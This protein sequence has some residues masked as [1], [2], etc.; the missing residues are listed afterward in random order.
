M[1][2][3]RPGDFLWATGIEDTFVPQSRPGHRALDEYQ[4]MG[5]YD[6]WRGDLALLR[7]TGVRAVRW[8]V[9][10][11][12]VEPLAGEYDW[13]WT[14]A[15]LPYL[16]EELGITPIVD[17]MHYGCPFWLRREFASDEYP[18]AVAAY[19]GAFAER[20]RHL[21]HW[22]TPLNE[23]IV[24][25]LFCGKRGLWPPYL[26]SDAGYV[27][28][29][30]QATRGIL[31]TIAA[32]READA[33]AILVHVDASGLS[34]TAR[35][36]LA[37]LAQ[38]EQSRT[39]LPTDLVTGRVT[40]EHSLFAWLVRSGASPDELARIAAKPATIDYLGLN[41]YP[42]WSTTQ[43]YIDRRGRLAYR[44]VEQEGEGFS[45]LIEEYH[46]RFQLPIIVTET[47]ARGGEDVR[48]RWL[49]ASVSAIRELRAHG[50]PVLGYTW[51]PL[52]TMVDWRYRFGRGPIEEYYLE[53]GLYTLRRDGAGGNG[54]DVGGRWNATPLVEQYRSYTGDAES[55]IGPLLTDAGLH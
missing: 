53:L 10:W 55:A 42:Q 37:A 13:R 22:Y 23:P 26:R 9:P 35:T 2:G 8:G 48:A 11:Y 31:A 6:H 45:H 30:L 16:V 4:L 25:A 18:A 19:A 33:D 41:F 39:F 1:I 17:L 46:R 43:L 49:E 3:R 27:R 50:V 51:F 52:F 12:R 20:Y 47:S 5:H 36:D 24:T 28:I 54:D 32:L 34:R 38:E 44:P 21:V 14:D 15:V 40:P 29:L 7:E